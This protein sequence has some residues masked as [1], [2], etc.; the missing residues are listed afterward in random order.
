[1]SKLNIPWSLTYIKSL[2]GKIISQDS[3]SWVKYCQINGNYYYVKYYHRGGKGLRQW[4]GRSRLRGEWENLH[5]FA[6]L[7]I[8]TPKIIAYQE[9]KKWGLFQEGFLVTAALTDTCNL[10]EF[11]KTGHYKN[12]PYPTL[13]KILQQIALY[14]KKLH[15]R[16]FVHQ[17]LKWR[18]ILISITNPTSIYFIDCPLGKKTWR[19]QRGQLKDLAHLDKFA[20]TY[21][22]AK[23]RLYFY[24]CY[25]QRF[26]LK[27]QDK[28]IIHFIRN[29][30]Q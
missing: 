29:Y 22:P 4:L 26:Y 25:R 5:Y 23:L 7:A 24:S 9:F 18:N 19:F 13:K 27:L 11:F 6:T 3:L 1:M 15:D 20:A 8:P 28:N 17:D 30:W 21:L 2:P 10:A 12:Y 14:T 16:N